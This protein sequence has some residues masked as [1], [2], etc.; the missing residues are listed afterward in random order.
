MPTDV[1]NPRSV[2]A[3][4]DAVAERAGRLDVL[5]NNAGVLGPQSPIDAYPLDGWESA[6][7]TNLTGAFLCARKAFRQMRRQEPSGGRIINNGSLSAHVPRP[8]AV[9]YTVTK[10]GMT[11]LTKALALE[12]RQYGIACGQIDIGNAA[13]EMTG[14]ISTGALQPDGSTLPEPTIDATEVADAILYVVRLPLEAS[15]LSMTLMA[16]GMPFLGR[17]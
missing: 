12:G 11:G 2:D 10:H 4:F 13:S 3:L 1:T 15:V 7:A 17:G 16:T 9:G 6:V 14:A 5:V 8:G